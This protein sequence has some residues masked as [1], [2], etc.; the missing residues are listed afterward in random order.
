MSITKERKQGLIGDFRRGESDTGSPEI[1]IAILTTRDRR[2]HR[3]PAHAQEG[4]RQPA[5]SV[6][7]GQS[8][9]ATVG[10]P[11][12]GRPAALSRHHSTSRY[13]QIVG[14]ASAGVRAGGR[15]VSPA[16]GWAK[17]FPGPPGRSGSAAVSR[18]GGLVGPIH[19]GWPDLLSATLS[20]AA[21]HAD[22]LRPSPRLSACR[23]GSPPAHAGLQP[24][25]TNAVGIEP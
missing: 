2:G 13:S 18:R 12:N 5:R 23:I 21:A 22:V 10:L 8:A 7:D 19:A 16:G 11:E 1:Q 17:E 25:R 9:S 15:F 14:C 6:D 20:F 24:K 3:A 4:L